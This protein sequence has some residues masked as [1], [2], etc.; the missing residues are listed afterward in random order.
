MA[1]HPEVFELPEHTMEIQD[2]NECRV[3]VRE[4][5]AHFN[6]DDTTG[7]AI[8]VFLQKTAKG[9]FFSFHYKVCRTGKF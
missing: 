8:A 1:R 5:R 2:T 4:L 6:P 7:P 9:P 3:T